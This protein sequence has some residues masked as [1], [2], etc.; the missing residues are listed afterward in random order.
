MSEKR[1]ESLFLNGRR[2]GRNRR[3]CPDAREGEDGK[4]QV[5]EGERNPDVKNRRSC[6]VLFGSGVAGVYGYIEGCA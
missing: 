2:A 6:R 5:A 3:G 1:T 4:G